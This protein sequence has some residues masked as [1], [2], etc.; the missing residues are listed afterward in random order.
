M[1]QIGN[2]HPFSNHRSNALSL[3]RGRYHIHAPS[4]RI[5]QS[6]SDAVVPRRGADDSGKE[7]RA[8]KS[9]TADHTGVLKT[10]RS[11]TKRRT[12]QLNSIALLSASIDASFIAM[13]NSCVRQ[14]CRFPT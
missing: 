7:L 9:A 6:I 10:L 8:K 5:G 13:L 4:L 14:A 2:D 12:S 11:G 1:A 3:R